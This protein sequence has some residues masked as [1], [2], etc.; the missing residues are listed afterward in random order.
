MCFR[1]GFALPFATFKLEQAHG[2]CLPGVASTDPDA[3]P[4]GLRTASAVEYRRGCFR[5]RVRSGGFYTIHASLPRSSSRHRHDR[6]LCRY[7]RGQGRPDRAHY[8]R[9]IEAMAVGQ[10]R[11]SGPCAL[12]R[13]R[14]AADGAGKPGARAAANGGHGSRSAGCFPL[15]NSL[16]ASMGELRCAALRRVCPWRTGDRRRGAYRTP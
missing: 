12:L 3:S 11:G 7:G 13:S 2:L 8:R 4:T 14:H 5:K 1:R 6:H 10:R 16:P 9:E 15:P